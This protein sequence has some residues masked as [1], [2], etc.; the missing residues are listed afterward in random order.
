MQTKGRPAARP[1]SASAAMALARIV[2]DALS[3]WVAIARGSDG[4]AQRSLPPTGSHEIIR[5]CNPWHAVAVKPGAR[6]CQACVGLGERR[7][8]SREAPPTPLAEC[9]QPDRCR[10]VYVHFPDRR[11]RA[12]RAAEG[13]T[14]DAIP[15]HR[16]AKAGASRAA[17]PPGERRRTPGRRATDHH[18]HWTAGR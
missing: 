11:I 1:Q 8:L 5:I 7:F 2:G 3:R 16:L 6:A 15:D 12:R 13:A 17:E 14:D 4:A 18:W 10:C 9:T